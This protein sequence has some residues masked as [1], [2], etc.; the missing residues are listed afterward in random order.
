MTHAS[1]PKSPP[2]SDVARRR[3]TAIL[4]DL[5]GTL[6]AHDPEGFEAFLDYAQRAGL[7]LSA[8]QK[9]QCERAV[10]RYWADGA[11]VSGHLAR[12]DERGF[13]VNYNQV[14]LD[15]MGVRS[16]DDCAHRIQDFF[17][18]YDPADVLFP[19]TPLVLARLHAE[20]YTLGLVS[21]RDGNLDGVTRNYGIDRYF[22]FTLSGGQA[23]VFKPDPAIFRQALK[24]A[25]GVPA[26]RAV[27]IGDNY[28]AD[29]L[30]ARA[31][32]MDAILIDPRGVFRDM[33]DPSV[34]RLRD[35]LDLILAR[36][37]G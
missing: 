35:V 23:G 9:A 14:L 31:V 7:S 37:T 32:G 33:C 21:N 17:E 20:G 16:C 1:K 12:F 13:W 11:Q 6:R 25:G 5:D 4:F 27:Y 26:S 36:A 34:A 18:H 19:D 22:R 10:H 2:A 28:Y 8:L 30:G 15:A 29:V 3:Y 24:L